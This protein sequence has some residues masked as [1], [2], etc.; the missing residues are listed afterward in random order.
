[1]KV[2]CILTYPTT[3]QIQKL[4]DFNKNQAFGVT[5]GKIYLVLALEFYIK[6]P[7]FGTG[8]MI[9]FLDDDGHIGFAPL[10]LF[11]IVDDR[12]SKYWQARFRE[13][14]SLIL[15]PPSFYREYYHDDLSEDLPEVV[16]DFKRVRALLESEAEKPKEGATVLSIS[17]RKKKD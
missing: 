8:V 6:L 11:D 16:E 15:Q 3:E 2:K 1:M 10:F 14:G 4:G 17:R 5:V 9:Q 12:S 13:D 7:G